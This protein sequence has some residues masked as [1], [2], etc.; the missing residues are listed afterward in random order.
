V[1]RGYWKNIPLGVA[2]DR[3]ALTFARREALVWNDGRLSYA[4]LQMISDRLA[5]QYLDAGLK[6]SD[7]VIMQLPN[8]PEFVYSYLALVKIGVIPVLC[9]PAHRL[10]EL[11]GIAA[12]CTARGYLIPDLYNGFDYLEL[13]EDLKAAVSTVEKV[14]VCG[15]GRGPDDVSIYDLLAKEVPHPE[16]VPEVLGVHRPDP[17]EPAVFLLSGGTT[18]VPKI[19]PR[20]HNDYLY[21]SEM[22]AIPLGLNMYSVYLAVAPLGHNMTLACPGIMGTFLT[23][24]KVVLGASTNVAE[25]CRAVE[26]EKVT[27][28]PV[29]PALVIGLLN[30]ADRGR[31]DLSSL[32]TIVSGGA[33]LNPE[34]A[35][36]VKPELG[37]DLVQQ[38]GMAEGLLTMTD[39]DDEEE[40]RFRTIGRP[41]SPGD[42]VKVVDDDGAEV[43][44]GRPGELLC[45]G[46][47][48][49]RGYYN[50]PDHNQAAFT[51]DGFYR[52]GDMVTQDPASGCLIIEGRKKDMINRGGEK[53]SAEEVENLILALPK[54][55]NVAVVAMPDPVLGERSCAYVTLKENETLTLEELNRFLLT[56]RI[57]KYKLPERLEVISQFPLTNVG[58]IRKNFLRQ[59]IE[60]KVALE[61]A[62][63]GNV[64]ATS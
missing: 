25:I 49:I 31:Y 43:P 36:R 24:G 7:R 30:F 45:R 19:I 3:A 55:N 38:F 21:T 4:Q 64:S 34:V 22:T 40:V 12:K 18:G 1:E 26:K 52:T 44:R 41:V 17:S 63:N 53:I 54:V 32:K 20:T 57:A 8:I 2:F 23:G 33:K 59:D 15:R 58:K 46:P 29:V 14:L 11:A 28:L 16:K 50:A 42:E 61:L 10:T 47:Y 5:F 13:A 35:R 6:P 60:E 27:V 56:K 9:L 62:K 48:T 37:C 51:E 39:V